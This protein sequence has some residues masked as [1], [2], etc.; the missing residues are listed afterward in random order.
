MR[1][2]HLTTSI[3]GGAGSAALRLHNALVKHGHSSQVISNKTF[4][5]E[6][7]NGHFS[8][9]KSQSVKSKINTFIMNLLTKSPFTIMTPNSIS[10]IS[11]KE[12]VLYNPE[13]VHI[14]NWFN[15]LNTSDI[16]WILNNYP[17]VFTLHDERIMTGGCHYRLDC[18]N[19]NEGCKKCPGLKIAKKLSQKSRKE[20]I[21][22]F[23][24]NKNR[25][26]LLTPSKSLMENVKKDRT[27]RSTNIK[28]VIPNV[29]TI[30]ENQKSKLTVNPKK[31]NEL[32]ILLLPQIVVLDQK[33]W[34]L[35]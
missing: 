5:E 23:N 21:S 25:F 14:H 29:Y 6:I 26:A 11:R 27:G 8:L 3:H 13:I 12:I 7:R 31:E 15:L 30:V 16:N 4:F 19:N 2:L 10:T 33:A 35:H 9:I 28:A 20:L 32:V 24:Q 1:I 18:V 17:T 22:I 34:I